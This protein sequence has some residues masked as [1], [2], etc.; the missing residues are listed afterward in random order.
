MKKISFLILPF[1]IALFFSFAP[2]ARASY[3]PEGAVVKTAASPDVYIIKY[4]GGQQFKRLVLNPQV[5]DSYGHLRWG[6]IIT[7]PQWEM[8]TFTESVYVR[9]DGQ[10]GI[11]M[12][13]PDGDTGVKYL[14]L[15][16]YLVDTDFIYTINAIDFRNYISG[17]TFDLQ[18]FSE[19]FR[20]ELAL[21][22][23]EELGTLIPY[24]TS[25]EE[26]LMFEDILDQVNDWVYYGIIPDVAVRSALSALDCD[27][28]IF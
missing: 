20:A 7:I 3:I 2:E 25:Y 6:D 9:V 14:T 8:D 1:I 16:D 21:P 17:G 13:S 18:T 24:T 23:I 19:D 26:I 12:L 27:T 11:W 4:S 28:D 10:Q 22:I 15:H 5:F